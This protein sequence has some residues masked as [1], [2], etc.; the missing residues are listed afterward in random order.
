M[1]KNLS[2]IIISV[3]SFPSSSAGDISET[4]IDLHFHSDGVSLCLSLS[5]SEETSGCFLDGFPLNRLNFKKASYLRFDDESRT[6]EILLF[7]N[8]EGS[9]C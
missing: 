5:D 3:I 7:L 8:G 2:V 1:K 4:V 6:L 9:S